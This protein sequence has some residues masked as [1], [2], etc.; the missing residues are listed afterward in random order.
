MSEAD[1][2]PFCRPT[3]EDEEIASVDNLAQMRGDEPVPAC[4]V[5][6][7]P[8]QGDQGTEHSDRAVAV[9]L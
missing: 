7:V 6:P 4:C 8:V 9:V 1:F 3:I 2:I 5:R